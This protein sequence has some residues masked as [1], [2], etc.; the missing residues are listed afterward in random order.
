[1]LKQPVGEKDQVKVWLNYNDVDQNLYMPLTYS[2][3]QNL[4][5][6]YIKDYNGGLTG[7]KSQDINYYD[8]NRGCYLNKDVFDH[9]GNTE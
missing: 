4:D 8:Y 3:T 5:S 7:I 9:S 2:Q 1:M 6:N